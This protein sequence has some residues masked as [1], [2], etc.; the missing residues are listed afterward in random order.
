MFTEKT[1][2]SHVAIKMTD[3]STNEVIY[4]QASHTMVNEMSEAEFLSQEKIV[5]SFDFNVDSSIKLAAQKFAIENLGVPYGTLSILGLA[6][7]QSAKWLGFNV[8][9][10]FKDNGE[11]YVCDQFIATMLIKVDG[12]IL[13][14]DINDLTPKDLY[15]IIQAMPKQW[16]VT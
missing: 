10:P 13:P 2:Y 5:Y 4:Y 6:Y 14:K 15:P 8:S 9:N 1:P 11:T 12:L 7:V 3:N 16:M